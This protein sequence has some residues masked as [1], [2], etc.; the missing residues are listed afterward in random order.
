[1]RKIVSLLAVL[2]LFTAMAY[3]QNR[4]VTGKV[5]DEKGDPIPFATVAIKGTRTATAAD[6]NGNFSIN[7]KEGSTLIVSSTGFDSREVSV[8]GN[9]VTVSLAGTARAIDEVIVTAGGIKA[10]RKEI[11][12]ANT[13]IKADALT[14]GKALN[15][16]GG[17]QGKVAGMQINATNGGVNPSFRIVLR[18][19]RSLTGNNQALLVVD[20]VIVPN[21]ILGNINPDD[22]EDVVVLNGAGAAALYGSQASNGAVIVTTKKRK[23]RGNCHWF[24]SYFNKGVSCFFPKNSKT[25]WFR[26][27][28]LWCRCQRAAFIQ[29][30]REP[31][32]RTEV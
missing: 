22:V 27:Y 12:T 23:K 31:I 29:L 5:R 18:G 15:V 21:D 13:V 30:S 25:I 32:L 17:L 11:G 4:T 20:N 28:R 26:R 9:D 8:Q 6:A 14:A 19:Q 3:A 16:A 1:M 24:V 2:L 7:L 10:K